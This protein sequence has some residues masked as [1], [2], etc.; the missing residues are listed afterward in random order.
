MFYVNFSEEKC[1][2][3]KKKVGDNEGLL[4]R[5]GNTRFSGGSIDGVKKKYGEICQVSSQWWAM[6]SLP[7][8]TFL[9]FFLKQCLLV[10]I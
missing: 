1:N 8:L 5:S 3:G 10:N 6:V 4:S 7:I 9:Y 2:F